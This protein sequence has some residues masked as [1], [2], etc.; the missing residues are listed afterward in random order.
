ME[1]K[2]SQI[3]ELGTNHLK[4]AVVCDA[5]SEQFIFPVWH[6][7]YAAV[8]GAKNLYVITYQGLG[9]KFKDVTLGGSIELPVV[10]SDSIRSQFISD[11]VK[12]LL[13]V[14]DVVIRVDA[15]E[16]LVVDPRV[17]A[18]LRNFIETNNEPYVTARGFDVTQLPDEQYLPEHINT[19]LLK[20]RSFAYP[21]T[22]LNKTCI[23][24]TPVQWSDGFHWA[25]V[26]PKFGPVFMLHMKRID[27]Q[28]QSRWFS[29][30]VRNIETDSSASPDLLAYYRQKIEDIERYHLDVSRRDRYSGIDN[31]Y[32]DD[33]INGF[34][35]KIKYDRNSKF[36]T[37][38][39]GHEHALCEIEEAW[40]VQIE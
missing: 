33:L 6:K 5:S 11:F 28:W 35:G 19:Q 18:S 20:N 12:T 1:T 37:G 22:A 27:M 29:E 4:I 31:W 3:I 23:I 34:L 24:R 9:D 36:Y 17:S 30:M 16:F 21:N 8:A 14:Y 25:N 7:Y 15:D 38:E 26:Y 40:K 13:R 39:Y 2:M 32:R 10:Y